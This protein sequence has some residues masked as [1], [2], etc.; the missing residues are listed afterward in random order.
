MK[1]LSIS[2]IFLAATWTLAAADTNAVK[3]AAPTERREGN[4]FLFVVETSLGMARLDHGG[5]QAVVDLIY[6]GIAGQMREGDTFAIWNFN[7]NVFAGIYPMQTWTPDDKELASSAGL[8]L[9][10]CPYVKKGSYEKALKEVGGLIDGIRDVNVFIVSDP[11]SRPPNDILGRGTSRTFATT[12]KQA[13]EKKQPVITTVVGRNGGISNVLVTV[14]TDPIR[15]PAYAIPEHPKPAPVPVVKAP[16]PRI[17]KDPIIITNSKQPLYVPPP[18]PKLG[19]VISGSADIS[20]LSSLRT[21]APATAGNPPSVPASTVP[22]PAKQEPISE[23]SNSPRR[24]MIIKT[25]EPSLK[26]NTAVSAKPSDSTNAQASANRTEPQT[27]VLAAGNPTPPM[28]NATTKEIPSV[29]VKPTAPIATFASA[30]N[31]GR[32]KSSET[33][34]GIA[35]SQPRPAEASSFVPPVKVSARENSKPL[36][37]TMERESETKPALAMAPIVPGQDRLFSPVA[38]IVIGSLLLLLAGTLAL[39]AMHFFRR[40]PQPT[41]ITQSMDHP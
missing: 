2:V 15:L 21:N 27:N 40:P 31:N 37:Q 11:A 4:R 1:R 17:R 6:T 35:P 8:F 33:A 38:M 29:I 9:K 19:E 16:A 30:E 7:D 36:E 5:R 3:A 13:R 25:A 23:N 41:F 14:A 24:V 12:A 34:N 18:K 10:G 39:L 26:T 22:L 20:Y 28:A 32:Q